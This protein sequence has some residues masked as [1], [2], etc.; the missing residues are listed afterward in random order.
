[1]KCS[2]KAVPSTQYPV[3]RS[4][5]KSF[6]LA[7][8]WVLGTGY[9][10]RLYACPFCSTNVTNGMAKGFFWSILLMLAVPVVVVA[11]I[12]G[13]VWRAGQKKKGFPGAHHE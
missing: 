2:I 11:T 12:A 9:G 1:M 10:A 13:V 8:C 6:A 3:L 4:I 5:E 7:M